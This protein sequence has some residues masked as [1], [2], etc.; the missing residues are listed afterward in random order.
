[1]TD[2]Q[3]RFLAYPV[4]VA[5]IGGTNAR[6]G[7]LTDQHAEVRTFEPVGT[8]TFDDISAAIEL[9]GRSEAQAVVS[10]TEAKPAQWLQ[11]MGDDGRLH[12]VVP[13]EQLYNRQNYTPVYLP[14][15][16]IYVLEV[17][18]LRRTRNFFGPRTFGYPMPPERAVDID[19]EADFLAAEALMS[20]RLQDNEDRDLRRA[21]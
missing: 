13:S 20:E 11:E 2:I 15:G 7:I 5:D 1:M 12:S 9:Y 10:V 6:F 4:L 17:E 18:A 8:A 3:T 14:N 19:T 21:V 16:S